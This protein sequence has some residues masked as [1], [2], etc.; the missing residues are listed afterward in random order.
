M[1]VI[2]LTGGIGS[3]KSTVANLFEKQG[4]EV[5][6]TDLIARELTQKGQP[7]LDEIAQKFGQ[8]ILNED[9]ELNRGELR[10][11]VFSDPVK[12]RWLEELLH[13]LIRNETKR[14]VE[15]SK[16]SYCIVI[17]PLL[18]ETKP[19]PLIDRILVVD[20]TEE[21]QIARALKRDNTS[22]ED[23][24]AI[25]KAQVTRTFRLK[26]ADDVIENNGGLELLNKQVDT[27]HQFYL[28]F[29]AEHE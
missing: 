1:K 20:T 25:M 3:G 13:P 11:Q 27:L 9:G 8:W 6:D 21:N 24:E 28:N 22:R 19:N 14:R 7:A 12:R 23:I 2:A 10:R 17:I 18:F 5:I 16:S 26:N 15:A 4:V 29:S